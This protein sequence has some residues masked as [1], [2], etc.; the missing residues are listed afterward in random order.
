[1]RAGEVMKMNPHKWDLGQR[2]EQVHSFYVRI[3]WK[4]TL[5]EPEGSLPQILNMHLLGY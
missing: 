2:P 1:M 5:H 3:L 4:G